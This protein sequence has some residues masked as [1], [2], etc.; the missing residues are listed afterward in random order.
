MKERGV[1]V[2]HSTLNRWVIKYAPEIEKQFRVHKRPGVSLATPRGKRVKENA[3]GILKGRE[4]TLPQEG[5][6]KD[7]QIVRIV[8]SRAV[9]R[10]P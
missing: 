9:Q 4:R 6:S 8:A 7:D 2:D 1:A 5:G 3:A 10:Y